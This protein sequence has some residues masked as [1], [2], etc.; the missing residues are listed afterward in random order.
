MEIKGYSL[1]ILGDEG[2][3][4]TSF[5]NR[6]ISNS[7]NESESPTIGGEYFQKIYDH[8]G[9]TI[10]I[11]IFG[12]SGK[13]KSQKLV[14]YLYKDARSIILMFNLNKKSTF[15]SL[16]YYLESIRINSVEDP[17][18]YIAGNFADEDS[19][20]H[21]IN[22][23]MLKEFEK[24]NN[25]K[26]FEISCK[27]GLGVKE[28]IE[29]L[30][31]D[32]IITEKWYS[33]IIDKDVSDISLKDYD[34]KEI[35][36]LSK[37]MK[38]YYKDSKE[39]KNN[40]IR[41]NVCDKLLVVKFRNTYNEVSFIC[42]TCK[43]E[44]NV[45][46]RKLEQ[47]MENLEEKIICFECGKQKEER[48]KL[49]YCNKCRH[50]ICPNCKKVLNKQFKMSGSELHKLYPYFLID[51]ICF[52][53]Y[54][55]V[56]GYC[57]KCQKN[58]CMKC[59][60]VH[61]G[62]ENIFFQEFFEQLKEK[63]K[64]EME[65]EIMIMNTFKKN[66]EDCIT[67]IRKEINNFI[68]IKDK[69]LK[70]K[71]QLFNQLNNIQWNY[72]LIETIKN[73]KY[74]KKPKYD[75]NSPWNQKLTDIFEVIGQP[76]QI[77]NINMNKNLNSYIAPNII[78]LRGDLQ[79]D[80]NAHNIKQISSY[81]ESIKEITDFCSMNKNKYLGVSFNT[82]ILELYEDIINNKEP[83]HSFEFFDK[84]EGIKSIYKSTRNVNNYFFCGKEKIKN[85][86]FYNNYET[87]KTMLEITDKKRF[88]NLTLEQNNCIIASDTNNKILIYD[89][90][91][92]KI[93]DLTDLIDSSGN[94]DIYSLKEIA[95][96]VL[97]ITFNKSK[98]NSSSASVSR[99]SY[100]FND[101]EDNTNNTNVD[102]SVIS[103]SR[104]SVKD[105]VELGTKIVELDEYN[106]YKTKREH[107]LSDNQE[108]LGFLSEKLIL[109]RDDNYNSVI[110]F[111]TNVFKN[112]QRF[113]F[114]LGEKPIYC[115]QLNKRP[116]LI[117]FVLVTDE[118]KMLQNI[119]DEEHKSVNQISGLKIKAGKD[120]I[121]NEIS[122][123]G[124]I[125]HIPFDRIIK[126]IGEN[127]FVVIKF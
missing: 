57:K 99:N 30:T 36:R 60:E 66:C 61:K 110:I 26:C 70:L 42:N 9:Q 53:H 6:F 4:K 49:E 59:F 95:N 127:N 73:F 78:K 86:E 68:M 23:D 32:I 33:T 25:L 87:Y 121:D 8:N 27:T 126:Y 82:G 12:T 44:T 28:L 39:K 63:N 85:V 20:R 122:K 5:L 13:K 113:Y 10:K 75:P 7:F 96:N 90:E 29:E 21:E 97:I 80:D 84:N 52:D 120:E 117:D 106:S 125:I 105:Q 3:G 64:E 48:L 108:F 88:F 71:E 43:T 112:V 34:E 72:Q 109:I 62:H 81:S 38:S 77:K 92:N 16:K 14:K 22:K 56:I 51:I 107:I 24:K 115:S 65:N 102:I 19:S 94:K 40:Y 15:N 47:Y 124:K 123:V 58:I 11:D 119:Y 1:S 45:D 74:L 103:A 31:K 2:V 98:D 18:V 69:E 111:D 37:T 101:T 114:E 50:Y 116:N 118:M 35:E 100:F 54:S 93:G 83:I 76:I 104:N 67:S 79:S 46:I 89:K 17:I 55:K 41:C 91:S